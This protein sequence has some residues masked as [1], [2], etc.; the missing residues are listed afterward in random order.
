M[1]KLFLSICIFLLLSC[2]SNTE[3]KKEIDTSWIPHCGTY[4]VSNWD[5]AYQHAD[6]YNFNTHDGKTVSR[7]VYGK[8][9]AFASD[10]MVTIYFTDGSKLKIHN[11]KYRP[12]ITE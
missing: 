4:Y 6:D 1:K 7:I 10:Y 2:A 5:V 9:D 3:A 8:S 12:D 11:Y